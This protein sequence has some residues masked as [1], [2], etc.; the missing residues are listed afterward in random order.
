MVRDQRTSPWPGGIVAFVDGR[1]DLIEAA[2]VP[3]GETCSIS[4]FS[5]LCSIRLLQDLPLPL[6]IA[7]VLDFG[8]ALR[9]EGQNDSF[10]FHRMASMF[11][12]LV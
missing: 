9:N 12:Y 11:L 1:K 3:A 8:S 7:D 6:F 5:E 2:R 10:A 4:G